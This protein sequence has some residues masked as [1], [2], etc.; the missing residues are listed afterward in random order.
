MWIG[1]YTANLGALISTWWCYRNMKET[2]LYNRGRRV[3]VLY[4][5][6]LMWIFRNH[7]AVEELWALKKVVEFGCLSNTN[8]YP[9]YAT[10]VGGS[11]TMTKIALCGLKVRVLFGVRTNNLDLLCVLHKQPFQKKKK[12]WWYMYPVFL[13]IERVTILLLGMYRRLTRSI[14]QRLRHHLWQFLLP[15]MNTQI[16]KL[17]FWWKTQ[18]ILH[19]QIWIQKG[20]KI[21]HSHFPR[22]LP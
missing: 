18:L 10:G 15:P 6:G 8:D 1:S 11:I 20:P 14:Q 13:K 5:L 9:T 21:S 17:R 7:F 22:T 4:E 3:G 12:K 16:W 2:H 19:N